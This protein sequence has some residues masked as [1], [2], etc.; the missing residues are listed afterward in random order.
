MYKVLKESLPQDD[1]YINKSDRSKAWEE[2]KLLKKK[3]WTPEG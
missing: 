1:M 3:K 2:E